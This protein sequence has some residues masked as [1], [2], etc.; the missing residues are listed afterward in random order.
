MLKSSGTE[1][2]LGPEAEGLSEAAP[3]QTANASQEV[4]AGRA[5]RGLDVSQEG[6]GWVPLPSRYCS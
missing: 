5:H 2:P 4:P 3:Q 6:R 1:G